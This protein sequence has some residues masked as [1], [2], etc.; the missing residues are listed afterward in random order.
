[1]AVGQ[2][3]RASCAAAIATIAIETASAFQPV[4]EAFWLPESWREANLRY[5]PFYGRGFIQLTWEYNYRTYGD[6]VGIDLVSDPDSALDP[7]TAAL[8]FAAYWQAHDLQSVADAHN[9]AEARRR[10]Q[11]ADAGLD[12]LIAISESLLRS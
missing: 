11:G 5:Y 7:G 12:R 1:M 10:V 9:W 3:S 6:R 2:A 8:V 4:R